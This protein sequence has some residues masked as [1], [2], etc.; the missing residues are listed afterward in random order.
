[1][2]YSSADSNNAV[3]TATTWRWL[4]NTTVEM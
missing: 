3:S 2:C 1:M 4:R